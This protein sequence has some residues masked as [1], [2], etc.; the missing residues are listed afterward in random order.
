MRKE[1]IVFSILVIVVISAIVALALV[2]SGPE[3]P[4]TTAE[5]ASG[6]QHA[7]FRIGIVSDV[8]GQTGKRFNYEWM[9]PKK[10]MEPLIRFSSYMNDVFHPD[11][12]VS[13]GDLIE[14]SNRLGQKSVTD[15]KFI[16]DSLSKMNVPVLHVIGN[17]DRRGLVDDDQWETL[18]GNTSTYSYHDAK[19]VRIV[20]LDYDDT[21]KNE[22]D[23]DT[24]PVRPSNG[25]FLVSEEQF[26]WLEKALSQASDRRIVV[27]THSPVA[28]SAVRPGNLINPPE[29]RQRLRDLFAKYRVSAVISGHVEVLRYEEDRGV[30]YFVVP[31]FH[32]SEETGKPVAWYGAYAGLT[33]VDDASAIFRYQKKPG[34][35]Y[36]QVRIPSSEFNALQK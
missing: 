9:E 27:F 6:L 36:E 8:H 33:L 22:S 20:L 32:R 17:H 4:E 10:V 3:R 21:G 11:I 13:A 12:V 19:D 5:S 15:F 26:E 2:L 16:T 18:T 30:R 35:D 1:R 29:Q 7:E 31:G 28:E 25:K 14:G 23:D 34:G 24:L